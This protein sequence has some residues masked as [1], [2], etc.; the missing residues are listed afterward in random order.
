MNTTPK[1]ND[2]HPQSELAL[3]GPTRGYQ[4]RVNA[5]H[6]DMAMPLPQPVPMTVRAEPRSVTL[7]LRRTA[8]IVI[9]MQND[10]CAKG[11]VG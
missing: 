1:R 3:L 2:P 10:F 6:V 9:D 8:T 7:D 5:E 11:G 4:W